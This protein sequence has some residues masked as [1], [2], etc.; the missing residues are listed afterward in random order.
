MLR[1]IETL[2]G[3][4][5]KRVEVLQGLTCSAVGLLVAFDVIN[6]RVPLYCLS[7][8]SDCVSNVLHAV[9]R[10]V[11]HSLPDVLDQFERN[12]LQLP[13]LSIWP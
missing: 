9:T 4:K 6:M 12:V 7:L 5:R 8:A 11:R 13:T 10:F 1:M 2:P 3:T